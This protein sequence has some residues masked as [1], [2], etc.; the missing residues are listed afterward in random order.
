MLVE[1]VQWVLS[2]SERFP[3]SG[4]EKS[5]TSWVDIAGEFTVIPLSYYNFL[6]T[7]Q[8]LVHLLLFFVSQ[9]DIMS[10]DLPYNVLAAH[11]S[12]LCHEQSANGTDSS[13]LQ[14]S[15]QML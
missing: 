15:C 6:E 4:E 3:L 7:S 13:I 5:F 14:G 1:L 9:L 10:S 2:N 8:G 11:V 12:L